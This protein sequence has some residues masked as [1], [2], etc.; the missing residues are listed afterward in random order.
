[1]RRGSFG[2]DLTMS[3]ARFARADLI[4]AEFFATSQVRGLEDSAQDQACFLNDVFSYQKE[5]EFEGELLNMVLVVQNF[6]NCD[7]NQAVAVVNDL[8]TARVE[9]F[10][11]TRDHEI[12]ALC[13]EFGFTA[14]Q[15]RAVDSYVRELEDWMAAVLNWHQETVRYGQ[16]ELVRARGGH[17]F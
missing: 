8:M 2:S 17:G 4:P 1:M 11:R 15:R 10:I 3:L 9:Q 13:E 6:L 12:P 14:E 16:D 5:I 7:K